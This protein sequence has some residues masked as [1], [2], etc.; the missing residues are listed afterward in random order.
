MFITTENQGRII[1]GLEFENQAAVS[2]EVYIANDKYWS[3]C[4]PPEDLLSFTVENE[5][6]NSWVGIVHI[7]HSDDKYSTVMQCENCDCGC[8]DLEA[9]FGRP[10][11]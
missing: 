7:V 5:D 4:F 2:G 9:M 11:M 3:F 6:G 1:I 10:I 8:L